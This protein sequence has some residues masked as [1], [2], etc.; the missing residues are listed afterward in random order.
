[1]L[2]SGATMVPYDDF[3][4]YFKAVRD[5]VRATQNEKYI[6]AYWPGF[7]AIAHEFGIASPQAQQH[8]EELDLEFS[9]M[10]EEL[11]GTDT[12]VMLSSDHG[13]IDSPKYRQIQV[14]QHPRLK[15]CL[16]MPL[17]GE[18]R[19]S[20]CYV[21]HDYRQSFESYVREEL[22]HAVDLYSSKALVERGLFGL[23]IP[24]KE[25]LSRVGDYTLVLKDDYVITDIIVGDS[26]LNMTGFHGGLSADEVYVPLVYAEC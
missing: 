18:P 24:H 5:A 23:G 14:A 11:A 17:C 25:L 20:Y 7:D 13:F 22:A 19:L 1:M 8:F 6:Y 4:A 12:V 2:T 9:N 10:L 16:M 26:P 15:D 21:R 3:H